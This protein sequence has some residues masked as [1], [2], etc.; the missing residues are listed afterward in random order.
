MEK[1][2]NANHQ[3]TLAA[4]TGMKNSKESTTNFLGGTFCLTGDCL[5]K[6]LALYTRVR[7]GVPVVLMGECGCGKTHLIKFL[8]RWLQA[9]L[10]VL[11]IHGG[12]SEADI[13][14][15]FAKACAAAQA[16]ERGKKHEVFVLLDEVNTCPHMGLLNDIICHRSLLGIDLPSNI[17]IL[18]ALNP[19]R[20]RAELANENPG[21]VFQLHAEGEGDSSPDAMADLV[22]KVHPIPLTML[23]FIFD[24]GALEPLQEKSYIESMVD[25]MIPEQLAEHDVRRLIAELINVSQRYVRMVEKDESSVSLRDVKRCINIMLWF[26]QRACAK[27]PSAKKAKQAKPPAGQSKAAPPLSPLAASVVMGLAFVYCYR[28]NNERWRKQYWKSLQS[29]TTVS[30]WFSFGCKA[31]T[32]LLEEDAFEK[33][34]SGVQRQ[35]GRQFALPPGNAPCLHLAG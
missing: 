28:L 22:Y 10:L 7:S 17:R 1:F 32:S 9:K 20:K 15:I 2:G 23:D 16:D 29:R 34:L 8:C 5:Q 11:D 26:A 4:L 13:L 27:P 14:G 33:V 6:M 21:L 12:T 3:E 24:F 30:G 31:F 19:Y 25:N 18:A 35:F